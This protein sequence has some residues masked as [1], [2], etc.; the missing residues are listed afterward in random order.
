MKKYIPYYIGC[1]LAVAMALAACTDEATPAL[2]SERE[3]QVVFALTVGAGESTDVQ[4]RASEPGW[5]DWNENTITKADIYIVFA[6][7]AEEHFPLNASDLEGSPGYYTWTSDIT[8]DELI[9]AT[10][11]VVANCDN[12]TNSWSGMEN[13][14]VTGLG[15]PAGKQESFLMD[16]KTEV[17]ADNIEGNKVITVD[18]KRAA[19]KIRLAFASDTDWEDVSYRFCQYAT[20]TTAIDKNEESYLGDNAGIA[21][22]PTENGEP[23]MAEAVSENSDYLHEYTH[24]VENEGGEE[25]TIT[26]K[27]LVLYSYANDWFDES[28]ANQINQVEPIVDDRQTYILLYAPYGEGTN[29]QWYY[30]KVP[31]NFRLPTNNDD[32][33][34][35]EDGGYDMIDPDTYR[36]LYRLQRN[37]IYDITVNI[38]RPGGTE[39]DPSKLVN[40]TYEV[41][42]WDREDVT[43]NYEDNLSY[44]SGGWEEDDEEGNAILELLDNDLTVHFLNTEGVAELTFT[45]NTPVV[46][47]WR[48]Q[49][50]GADI[51][52]FEFVDADGTP[53]GTTASGVASEDGENP[54]M[55]YLRI[56]CVEPDSPDSHSVTLQ[57]YADIA[58]Q[59]YE[60]D[61]TN[62]GNAQQPD[63][64]NDPINRFTILQ[65]Y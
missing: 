6:N 53:I 14:H 25:V 64:S 50:T 51:N 32:A 42:P 52:Y 33:I 12:S 37:Y 20:T 3:D 28:K 26:R 17:T 11:Y 36:H 62:P 31:V 30:Y 18:L 40:L 49:L 38:D 43:V 65:S 48:A 10:I 13:L 9:G 22:Y 7:G 16:G 27:G 45:I 21:T 2:S 24:I 41:N 60:M 39:L 59:T 23:S 8:A 29:K 61:L 57:V 47:T 15:N 56:R 5:G 35:N 63:D 34:P 54:T 55:Q 44:T 19:A 46:A 58:G 1:L 4:T